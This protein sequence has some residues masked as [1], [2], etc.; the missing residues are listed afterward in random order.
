MN[1]ATVPAPA[2]VRVVRLAPAKL[3]L[4]LAVVAGA[5]TDS[6]PCIR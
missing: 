5:R 6:T 1:P 3:N 2:G 4:T